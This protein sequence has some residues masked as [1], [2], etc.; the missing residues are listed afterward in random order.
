MTPRARLT[1]TLTNYAGLGKIKLEMT[2]LD[3][4]VICANL[5]ADDGWRFV[6]P[7][8]A[9]TPQD[10]GYCETCGYNRPYEKVRS[11]KLQ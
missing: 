10:I 1:R 7:V 5:E 3:F 4:E 11:S 2:P 8:C 6:C 9:K